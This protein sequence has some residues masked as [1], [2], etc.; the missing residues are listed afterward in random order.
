M[1]S[2]PIAVIPH[3]LAG[4]KPHVVQEKAAA[5]VDEI[6]AILTQPAEKLAEEYRGRFLK[7]ADKRIKRASA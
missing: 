1:G 6:L 3:P 5:I 7:P 2:I 4:N